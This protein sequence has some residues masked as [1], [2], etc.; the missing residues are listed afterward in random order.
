MLLITS[1][2]I[3]YNSNNTPSNIQK[4]RSEKFIFNEFPGKETFPLYREV[5]GGGFP[6]NAIINHIVKF[7]EEVIYEKD[8]SIDEFNQRKVIQ[9]EGVKNGHVIVAG[10]S[11][12][13]SQ[14]VNDNETLASQLA[15][16][17]RDKGI[18]NL[19]GLGF[20]PN[21][22]LRTFEDFHVKKYVKQKEGIFIYHFYMYHVSRAFGERDVV[23]WSLGKFPAYSLDEGKLV[24]AG[25]YENLYHYHFFN[26]LN[27]LSFFDN[28]N[29][30]DPFSSKKLL[31]TT[32][33]FKKMKE[34]YLKSFPKG[35][36]YIIF[37]PF[38]SDTVSTEEFK[39]H[40]R[41]KNI[42]F[43]S[44]PE[45]L[46]AEIKTKKEEVRY[47]HD[48]HLTPKGYEI[49]ADFIKSIF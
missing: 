30:S 23:R 16:R 31:L 49:L 14:G 44:P 20:G 11:N 24:N 39:R 29:F 48:Y 34:E 6:A 21:H 35:K 40:L 7:G 45:S 13:F 36:F 9:S 15:K 4:I 1:G 43:I 8:Y 32:L 46:I 27:N 18:Y 38:D 37:S 2:V 19:S 5:M 47:P 3:I 10:G 22:I 12:V 41:E 42:D 33:I 17:F 25:K 28:F 26:L